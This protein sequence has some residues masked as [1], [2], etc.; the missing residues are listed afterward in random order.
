MVAYESPKLQVRV[1][2]LALLLVSEKLSVFGECSR[3][4][5]IWIHNSVRSEAESMNTG[6]RSANETAPA[7]STQFDFEERKL[8]SLFYMTKRR[9]C[10]LCQ[11]KNF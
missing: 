8:S 11:L 9:K 7:K 2:V 1:R 6:C 4:S 10:V 5:A 3:S